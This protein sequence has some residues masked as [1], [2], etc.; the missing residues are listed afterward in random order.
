MSLIPAFS[1]KKTWM[2]LVLLAVPMNFAV[3]AS[4]YERSVE[5]DA[6]SLSQAQVIEI[7]SKIQPL[8]ATANANVKAVYRK[9]SL[10]LDDGDSKVSY[11]GTLRAEDFKTA[12]K[13]ATGL[14]YRY[15]AV[16]GPVE[17]VT[18]EFTDYS[19][20]IS[21]SGSSM[22]QVSGVFS[23]IKEEFQPYAVFWSG[24]KVRLAINM[25]LVVLGLILGFAPFILHASGRKIGD[26]FIVGACVACVA[27]WVLV[28]A[29][30]L[31]RWFPGTQVFSGESSFMV[32]Y[33]AEFGFWG[34][35]LSVVTLLLPL[36]GLIKRSRKADGNSAP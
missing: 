6:V 20:L 29:L 11:S 23:L 1:R 15:S 16:D 21:V 33:S 24:V 14:T 28:G 8:L 10:T 9:E 3:A 26:A 25:I 31:K 19:R 30:P 7:F 17:Y 34:F 12:P 22:E 27:C 35:F 5:L 18:V 13:V 4:T 32:R 36:M 2:G